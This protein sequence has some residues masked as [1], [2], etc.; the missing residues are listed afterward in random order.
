MWRNTFLS[1]STILL[2]ALILFLLN[3]VF[4]LQFFAN[5]SLENLESRADFSVELRADFDAFQLEALTNDLQNYDL[6]TQVRPAQT[7][8]QIALPPRLHIR[9][10]DITQVGE[11]FET[12]KNPRY[13]E[14]IGTWDGTGERDFVQVIDQLL[15][16]RNGV[17][18]A[19]LIFVLIFL[20]GGVL[21]V[22][23]TFR[24]VLFSR[25]DEVFIA[26]LV[27]ADRG[28]IAGPFVVEGI[29]LGLGASLVG[30]VLFTL[31]L[32]EID[33]LPGGEIFLYLWNDVFGWQVFSAGLVGALGAWIAVKKYLSGKLTH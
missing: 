16:I 2:G 9:F 1:G 17:E 19:S 11:V 25:R 7:L 18:S 4:S 26:R 14:V 23:N 30:I 20:G 27:G 32:R 22:V 8:D 29:L 21:L 12:L 28:F 31:A 5:Y 6:E 15:R 3:I 33:L 24:I 13:D 10:Q